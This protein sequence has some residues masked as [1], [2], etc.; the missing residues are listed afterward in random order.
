MSETLTT[1]REILSGCDALDPK[2]W[3]YLPAG[4][5]SLNTSAAVLRSEEVPPG[6]E[7]EP[8]AGVPQFAKE[9]GLRQVLPVTT[10]QDI[11]DNAHAQKR[12]IS[13]NELLKAFDYYY[14][15]DAFIRL[16]G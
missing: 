4:E 3:V 11:V 10:V 12:D 7:N 1:L 14:K 6:L 9:H 16:E 8:H 13:V 2:A 5:W 15:H